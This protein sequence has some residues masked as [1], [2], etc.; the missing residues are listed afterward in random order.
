MH[1]NNSRNLKTD[2]KIEVTQAIERLYNLVKE[3]EEDKKGKGGKERGK[4]GVEL[5]GTAGNNDIVTKMEEHTKLLLENSKK[6]DHLKAAIEE[7]KGSYLDYLGVHAKITAL[8]DDI[9]SYQICLSFV[10]ERA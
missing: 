8:G 6:L 9:F 10:R 1:L 2:I 5:M 3:L 7:Q 4:T